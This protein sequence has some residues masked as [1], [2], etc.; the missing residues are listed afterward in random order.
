MIASITEGKIYLAATK[1]KPVTKRNN[2]EQEPKSHQH[3]LAKSFTDFKEILQLM[4]TQKVANRGNC[5]SAIESKF[6][7]Q[8]SNQEMKENC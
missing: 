6:A 1:S 8:R 7:V 3:L 4:S 5:S 2:N